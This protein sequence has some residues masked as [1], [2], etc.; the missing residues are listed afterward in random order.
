M[1]REIT[2]KERVIFVTIIF[3]LII[4]SLYGMFKTLK[5]LRTLKERKRI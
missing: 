4:W 1:Q 5:I 3:A 2:E